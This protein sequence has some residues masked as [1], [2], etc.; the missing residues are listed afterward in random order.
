VRT[1]CHEGHKDN[2]KT[3][4]WVFQISNFGDS[5]YM[6]CY[7]ESTDFRSRYCDEWKVEH[8]GGS[9]PFPDFVV[10]NLHC[11]W[12]NHAPCMRTT[13]AMSEYFYTQ[14]VRYRPLIGFPPA[15][16][17]VLVGPLDELRVQTNI[18]TPVRRRTGKGGIYAH[19]SY[20]FV[21]SSL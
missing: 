10:E 11:A 16:L 7:T 15:T 3:N 5:S 20:D 14:L 9:V 19:T 4:Y 1:A 21:A 13:V 2:R 12:E 6:Q 17:Q 18:A 8:Y